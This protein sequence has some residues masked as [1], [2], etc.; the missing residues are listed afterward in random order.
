MILFGA[1]IFALIFW[2]T[3]KLRYDIVALLAL[4][5][6]I[7]GGVVPFERA[8]LGFADPVV[9][10]VASVLV[11]SK[12]ITNTK[13]IDIILHK[14][15]IR[16]RSVWV[17]IGVLSLLTAFISTFIYN[18]GALTLIMPLA[19]SIARKKEVS[20]AY[21]LMPIAFSAHMGGFLTLIG[22]APNII[23]SSFRIDHV[24]E[25]FHMFDFGRVGLLVVLAAIIFISLIGWRLIPKKRKGEVEKEVGKIENYTSELLVPEKSDF[26]GNTIGKLKEKVKEDFCVTTIIRKGEKIT[27]VGDLE[28]INEEDLILIQADAE[29]LRKMINLTDFKLNTPK[30][31]M[32]RSEKGVEIEAIV[33]PSSGIIGI[34]VKHIKMDTRYDIEVTAISRGDQKITEK[35]KDIELKVGDVLFLRGEE[36][37]INEFLQTSKLLPLEKRDISLIPP[38]DMTIALLIIVASV[39][40]ATFQILPT[41]I[42]FFLGALA[43]V[44]TQILNPKQIY[45]SID[46]SIIIILGAMIPF[47]EAMMTSGAADSIA[48]GFFNVA[49]GVEPITVLG[50]VLV[51]SI[52]MSDFVNNV[53]VA[54]LMAPIALLLADGL[55]VSPDPFLMAVA[56]GGSCAFLTPIGHQVNL[57]VL[58]P[59]GYEFTDYWKMGLWLDL[60]VFVI[61]IVLLPIMWPL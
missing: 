25:P 57:L 17:Q 8:F 13:L 37:G 58:K 60:L 52:I 49:S 46:W 36:D 9:I 51:I 33:N 12:G 41:E 23:V 7:L 32:E 6:I 24:G 5:I 30:E 35:L 44:T 18:A 56:I 21:Y 42:S 59:G 29:T 54:V 48:Q 27:E 10:I 11:I 14:L 43:M 3:N 1:M 26:I 2:I 22:N 34:P 38:A 40:L 4:G 19:I 45:E 47:G 50:L 55:G 20:T 53:G 61:A 39:L 15:P 16:E 31:E 28:V